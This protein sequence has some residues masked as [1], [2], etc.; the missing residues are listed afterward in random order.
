MPLPLPARSTLLALLLAACARPAAPT[1]LVDGSARRPFD[2]AELA[3]GLRVDVDFDGRLR[4]LTA[5]APAQ[6]STSTKT[7]VVLY[8]LVE[9]DLAG[10]SP[11]VFVHVRV[12]G[13]EQNQAQA[14]HD[15]PHREDAVAGDVIVDRFDVVVP[16]SV[17]GAVNVFA[18]IYEGKQR[19]QTRPQ[20][21]DDAVAVARVD[22]EGARA[23][24]AVV[25]R[26]RGAIVV[27]GVFDEADWDRAAVLPLRQHL[28]RATPILST[29][30]KLLWTPTHLYLAFTADDPDPFSPYTKRDEPLY[31]G[32]AYEIFVDADGDGAAPDGEYVELQASVHDVHFDSAFAGGRRQH[33]EVGYDVPFE[34]KTVVVDSAQGRQVGKQVG[35]QV[36]QEWAIPVAALRGIPAGEPRAGASWHIN[37]FRLE[38]KRRGDVVVGAEASAWSPPLSNDFHNVARF[39]VVTFAE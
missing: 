38:R 22:V 13:A 9:R 6:T 7:P 16:A 8:W 27:D 2:S 24:T 19:W 1:T 3:A 21:S 33:M 18:G 5:A 15:L 25:P 23:V 14:D 28:G 32:E 10:R 4:L 31:Q 26:A 11:R 36:H 20:A 17:D 12:D 29:T 34:T 35:K 37:L 39:G 30:A